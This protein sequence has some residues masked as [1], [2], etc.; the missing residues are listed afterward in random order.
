MLLKGL[1]KKYPFDGNVMKDIGK[2]STDIIKY[3]IPPR[4]LK[5]LKKLG[6]QPLS[7]THIDLFKN[8]YTSYHI[9]QPDIKILIVEEDYE[10]QKIILRFANSIFLDGSDDL[11]YH[12]YITCGIMESVLN[13]LLK[14][15]IE[16]NIEKINIDGKKEFCYFDIIIRAS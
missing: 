3:Y 8:I 16:I 5:Q 7:P 12:F 6:P 1:K 2:E 13:L 14:K 10:N 11:I 9:L 15:N 4:T